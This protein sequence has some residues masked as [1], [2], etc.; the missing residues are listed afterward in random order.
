VSQTGTFLLMFSRDRLTFDRNRP[1][2]D[3]RLLLAGLPLG[4]QEIDSA[5]ILTHTR[6]TW[7]V[8]CHPAK[9]ERAR[10]TSDIP[11][12]CASTTTYPATTLILNISWCPGGCLAH[13]KMKKS[14]F[15]STT[16]GCTFC[17]FE[18]RLLPL[19]RLCRAHWMIMTERCQPQHPP[20]PWT[21]FPFR[22]SA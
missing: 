3:A 22:P 12:D 8:R 6:R 11:I 13:F 17:D 19:N 9:D 10:S 2:P 15:R 4:R 16:D 5:A 18:N 7:A 20:T 21:H 1:Q 14:Y